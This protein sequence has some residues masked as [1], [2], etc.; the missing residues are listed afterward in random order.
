[1]IIQAFVY[2]QWV[3]NQA[4][5]LLIKLTHAAPEFEILIMEE[6]TLY[7]NMTAWIFGAKL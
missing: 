6:T 4:A 5:M 2:T 7:Y 3:V 1:M